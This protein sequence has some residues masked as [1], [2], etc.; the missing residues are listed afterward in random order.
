MSESQRLSPFDY[1]QIKNKANEPKKNI[2]ANKRKIFLILGH[3]GIGTSLI[4]STLHSQLSNKLLASETSISIFNLD[5]SDLYSKF[6]RE[7]DKEMTGIDPYLHEAIDTYIQENKSTE[8]LLIVLVLSPVVHIN[9]IHLM[10]LLIDKFNADISLTISLT[11]TG[12][13]QKS[14]AITDSSS[15]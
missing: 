9:F 11:S 2:S 14:N 4:V 13:L 3:A 10:S 12:W 7:A 6:G 15:K 5:F 8:V 1:H